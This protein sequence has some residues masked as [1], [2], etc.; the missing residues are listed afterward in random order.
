MGSKKEK[1]V[2]PRYIQMR[3]AVEFH[4]N[5]VLNVAGIVGYRKRIAEQYLNTDDRNLEQQKALIESYERCNEQ[6]CKLLALPYDGE[7]K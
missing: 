3:E 6:L 2:D 5:S 1:A 4:P 7:K